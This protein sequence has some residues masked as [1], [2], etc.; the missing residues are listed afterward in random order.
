MIEERDAELRT[1]IQF[2]YY[3]YLCP[4]EIRCQK[5]NHVNL[6]AHKIFVPAGISKNGK[7]SHIDIPAPFVAF[8]TKTKFFE[9]KKGYL[10][11]N[12][13]GDQISKNA[14]T[15]RHKTFIDELGM[16]NRHT[17]YQ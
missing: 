15:H 14:M 6:V 7:E 16:D 12:N 1:F 5:T 13:Q 4:A 3:S 9:H 17:L 11:T 8:L 2:I 10:F